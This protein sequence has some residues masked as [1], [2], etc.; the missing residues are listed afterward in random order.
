LSYPNAARPQFDPRFAGRIK[1][2]LIASSWALQELLISLRFKPLKPNFSSAYR[3]PNRSKGGGPCSQ[4]GELMLR[5]WGM[6]GEERA[7]ERRREEEKKE[8]LDD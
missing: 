6:L 4:I 5:M 3:N 2:C 8:D 1:T 7:T